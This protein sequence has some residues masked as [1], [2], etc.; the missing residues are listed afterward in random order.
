MEDTK[1]TNSS[2][3]LHASESDINGEEQQTQAS[4]R[5]IWLRKGTNYVMVIILCVYFLSYLKN[6]LPQ[7]Q[8]LHS[9]ESDCE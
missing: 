2:L 5:E 3:Q 1:E 6:E 7:L 4:L 9:L 8:R